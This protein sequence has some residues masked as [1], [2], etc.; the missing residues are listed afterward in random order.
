MKL[1][2]LE[3]TDLTL[4]EVA[5]LAKAGPGVSPI[6]R[7]KPLV[8]EFSPE[9]HHQR[10]IHCQ[11]HRSGSPDGC[12]TDKVDDS[13]PGSLI[14][15]VLQ[16]SFLEG[17]SC[18]GMKESQDDQRQVNRDDACT[19][20]YTGSHTGIHPDAEGLPGDEQGESGAKALHQDNEEPS[21]QP[22]EHGTPTCSVRWSRMPI[23]PPWLFRARPGLRESS[24]WS[25]KLALAWRPGAD[26]LP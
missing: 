20:Y 18:F 25:S 14:H 2:P 13:L 23:R 15:E 26:H 12:S 5:E 22:L 24:A 16:L 19:E 1:V 3:K 11:D 6:G 9:S 17:A 4:S 10:V 7:K 8:D 21:C